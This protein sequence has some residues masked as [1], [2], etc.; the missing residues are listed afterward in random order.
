MEEEE[1]VRETEGVEPRLEAT[2]GGAFPAAID[3]AGGVISEEEEPGGEVFPSEVSVLLRREKLG[4]PSIGGG[5]L[6]AEEDAKNEKRRDDTL[7]FIT[8]VYYTV[9]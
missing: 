4:R 6:C 8:V 3:E 1:F 2:F 7:V 5:G 9:K